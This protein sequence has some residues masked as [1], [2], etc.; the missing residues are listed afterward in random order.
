MNFD[1]C[2]HIYTHIDIQFNHLYL[3][4]YCYIFVM[5]KD[6][7]SILRIFAGSIKNC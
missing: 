6:M 2:I 5:V 3:L 7:F 1:V 4:L